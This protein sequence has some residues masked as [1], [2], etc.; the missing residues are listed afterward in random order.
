MAITVEIHTSLSTIEKLHEIAES[1]AKKISIDPKVLKT[2]L[3]DH[4]IMFRVISDNTS[5]KIKEPRYR[6]KL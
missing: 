4:S 1:E 6:E 5:F 3:L 2:L